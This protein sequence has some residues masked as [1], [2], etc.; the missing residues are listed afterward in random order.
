[1]RTLPVDSI[2]IFVVLGLHR[3]RNFDRVSKIISYGN[4][5]K[6]SPHPSGLS[7]ILIN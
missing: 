2:I 5:L 6:I 1:M 7:N 3:K 4:H